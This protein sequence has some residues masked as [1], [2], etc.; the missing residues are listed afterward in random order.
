MGVHTDV[1]ALREDDA[2]GKGDEEHAG[3]DPTVCHVGGD[4]VEV[5]LV[6]LWIAFV[7]AWCCSSVAPSLMPPLFATFARVPIRDRRTRWNLVVCADTAAKGVCW[8]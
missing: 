3:A 8:P 1:P 6:D 7:S 5:G 4:F 2:Q